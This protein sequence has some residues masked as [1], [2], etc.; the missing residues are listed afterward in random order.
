M[1]LIG[2][3]VVYPLEKS[4]IVCLNS[5]GAVYTSVKNLQLMEV[6][7]KMNPNI[8]VFLFCVIIIFTYTS[9]GCCL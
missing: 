4:H 5:Y 9:C 7:F 1:Q 3:L 8:S 6:G 2:S